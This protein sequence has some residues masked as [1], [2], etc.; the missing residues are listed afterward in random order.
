M[1][2]P[3]TVPARA[4]HNNDDASSIQGSV[5][6][7]ELMQEST[8]VAG[9]LRAK[10]VSI[11][12]DGRRLL[13]RIDLEV[14]AGQSVCLIGASG[15]GKTSLLNCFSG[16]SVP[17]HGSVWVGE[18]E[19]SSLR[20]SERAAFR[21][22]HIGI[23]FQFGELL[24]ELTAVENIALSSRLLGVRRESAMATAQSWLERFGMSDLAEA[25]PANLSGG[26]I[27]RVGI[28]RALAHSP[29]L[30]LADEP[31]GM[32]DE[33]NTELVANLLVD[34]AKALPA[35]VVVATHDPAVA[36]KADAVFR[37]RGASLTPFEP[38]ARSE[39]ARP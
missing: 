11:D 27:Q 35:A 34:T 21:L 25:H 4:I 14:E 19:L 2:A 37:L 15:V 32:L 16:L 31:T 6:A 9:L 20:A 1:H 36:T 30:V 24:P 38:V 5:E 39:A 18:T 7:A 12:V 28:A 8:L 23:V 13:E 33:A 22:R 10:G 26:E 29:S 3:S 17:D